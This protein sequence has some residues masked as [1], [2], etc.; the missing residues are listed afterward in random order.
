LRG[1]RHLFESDRAGIPKILHQT[2]KSGTLPAE[3]EHYR[4][5]WLG[6]HPTWEHRFYD[7]AACHAFVGSCGQPWGDLY[8]SLPT[9]I[10]RAD[11]FR[12]LVVHEKGGVYADIDMVCYR[13]IDEL[14]E[15]GSCV[16]SVEAHLTGQRRRELGFGTPRQLANCIFA[17][18]RGDPFLGVLL[19][20]IADLEVLRFTV[21]A[22][23]DVEEST[24]PRMLTRLFEEL[25][26]VEGARI[27]VLPQVLLMGPWEYP[28]IPFIGPRI[29][30]RHVAAGTWKRARGRNSLRRWWIE[31]NRLPDP[32]PRRP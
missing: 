25:D 31:R 4:D 12:Y 2:W 28:R 14:L 8:A 26:P 20:H 5:S 29:Y 23:N 27:R 18:K 16:L 22:D 1:R 3:F 9:A 19:A 6:H 21:H 11:L 13:P 30:A 7:D 17:A 10:Q 32:W 24:G 15:G